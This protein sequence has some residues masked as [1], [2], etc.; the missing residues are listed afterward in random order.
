MKSEKCPNP[1]CNEPNIDFEMFVE[2][3]KAAASE[4]DKS[5]RASGAPEH[6]VFGP[7]PNAKYFEQTMHEWEW[8]E[9][10]ICWLLV[11]NRVLSNV[12]RTEHQSR[13]Q[14]ADELKRTGN[15]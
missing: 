15:R 3:L 8:W 7:I 10:F 9:E 14:Y 12:Q 2:K 6:G 13:E 11:T 4:F 1:M 5:C